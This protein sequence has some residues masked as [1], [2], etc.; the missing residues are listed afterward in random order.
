MTSGLRFILFDHYSLSI[1][2]N[3]NRV[4]VLLKLKLQSNVSVYLSLLI[5]SHHSR[6]S[7]PTL[8]TLY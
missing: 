7:G 8:V 5:S 4:V 3:G 2:V 1:P 6:R